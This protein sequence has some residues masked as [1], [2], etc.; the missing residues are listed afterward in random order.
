MLWNP[1]F[2]LKQFIQNFEGK[3]SG[4][5]SCGRLRGG[6]DDDDDDDANE[7]WK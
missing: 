6:L 1:V 3:Y 7:R 4:K 2:H 5:E